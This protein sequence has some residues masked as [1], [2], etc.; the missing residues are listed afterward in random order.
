MKLLVERYVLKEVAAPFALTMSAM[1]IIMLIQRM[2][3]I[4]D[5]VVNRGVPLGYVMKLLALLLPFFLTMIT[6][7][8][9]LL[10][11][12]LAVN[13]MSSD[14]EITAL[15]ASG[16]SVA[17][18]LPPV[19]FL[20]ALCAIATAF[21][22]LYLIPHSA[23]LTERIKTDLLQSSARTLL[24]AKSFV[25]VGS[26]ITIYVDD[27]KGGVLRGVM[28]AGSRGGGKGGAQDISIFAKK[29]K[30]TS[31]TKAMANYL[32]LEDGGIHVSE[33]N[34]DIFR[35]IS[36]DEF[37]MKIDLFESGG[38]DIERGSRFVL[39]G[40]DALARREGEIKEK[41]RKL[42]ESTYKGDETARMARQRYRVA[43][44]EIG[45]ARHQKLSL[46]FACL[47]LALWGIPLGIQ[48]PRSSRNQGIVTSIGLTLAYYVLVNGGK[49]A[50]VRGYLPPPLA[51]WGP[52]A[53][54]MIT[55]SW[56]L[57]RV[58]RDRPI[59]LSSALERVSEFAMRVRSKFGGD[60]TQ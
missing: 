14:S 32:R 3:K 17:R 36:F 1:I 58:S 24:S 44:R 55:G 4:T 35:Y 5:W 11:T 57:F 45:V 27:I 43:L 34:N 15:K 22:N 56:F 46:P 50:A 19:I 47:I 60:K 54:V 6:P 18:L 51:V 42:E 33:A 7:A 38:G 31:D 10:A 52:N 16:I 13:R 26:G 40:M 12:L 25:P 8:A 59:P 21:L 29:G 39:M 28:V 37:D 41:L 49:M 30:I 48:P 53:I 20:G 2:I 23:R 9:L